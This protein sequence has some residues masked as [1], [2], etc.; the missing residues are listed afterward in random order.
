MDP[1]VL[2]LVLLSL[3]GMVYLVWA[4]AIVC[5]DYLMPALEE[6]CDLLRLSPDAASATFLAFGSSSPELFINIFG[7]ATGDSELSLSGLLGGAIIS[8]ALI[9]AVCV[10]FLPPGADGLV[11]SRHTLLRDLGFMC[12]GFLA[13]LIL[14]YHSAAEFGAVAMVL[15]YPLYVAVVL[16]GGAGG[17]GGGGGGGDMNMK[18]FVNVSQS[19]NHD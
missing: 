11:L 14:Q 5:D 13:V 10:Y 2:V 3:L 7:A 15:A 6:I 18:L 19:A 17:G 16:C 12:G 8:I 4:L 1:V 9:P